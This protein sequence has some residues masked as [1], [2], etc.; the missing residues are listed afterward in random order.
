MVIP[1]GQLPILGPPQFEDTPM[2]WMVAKS[3]S[4]HEMK[5][6]LTPFVCWYFCWRIASDT[7]VSEFGGAMYLD[8]APIHG[9]GGGQPTAIGALFREI[10]NPDQKH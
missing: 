1:K 7:G 5:P 8:F 10:N 4:H 6:W 3:I 9:R 2:P